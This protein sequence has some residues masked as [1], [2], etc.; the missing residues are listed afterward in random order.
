M[1]QNTVRRKLIGAWVAAILGALAI[2]AGGR[3]YIGVQN[4]KIAIPNPAM[5]T[6]NAFDK[7]IQAGEM[8]KAQ[9]KTINRLTDSKEDFDLAEA[10]TFVAEHSEMLRLVRAGLREDCRMPPARS[11]YALFPYLAHFRTLAKAFQIEGRVHEANG[12][13]DSAARSYTDC[14]RLGTHVTRGGVLIHGLVGVAVQTIGQRPLWKVVP[15]LTENA[16]R[17]AIE[18]LRQ[19]EAQTASTAE[20]LTEEKYFMQAGLLEAFQGQ[21][22]Q[23]SFALLTGNESDTALFSPL[24]SP[25][26]SWMYAIWSKKQ[27]MANITDIMDQMIASSNQPYHRSNGMIEPKLEKQ[28]NRDP[29]TAVMMPVFS[30]TGFVFARCTA[31]N[32]LLMVTLALQAH[33]KS[34]GQ[35]PDS[36]DELV[37]KGYLTHVPTD[38]FAANAPLRYYRTEF[39]YTLYSVGPDAGDDGGTA[40]D[41]KKEKRPLGAGPVS[42]ASRYQI[43]GLS[44]GDIVAGINF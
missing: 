24:R 39:A 22:L 30:S 35:Y 7:Y 18:S 32:H 15:H 10:R 17:Q 26:N 31:Q 9:A 6:P 37:T 27:I 40:A 42:E 3:W 13:Y 1:Y 2:F 34:T 8:A 38:P 11:F 33:H 41:R 19:A 29:I 5:P 21:L 43:D 44:E 16:A 36:L 23:N 4:P 28:M 14:I 20:I 12:D 25:D